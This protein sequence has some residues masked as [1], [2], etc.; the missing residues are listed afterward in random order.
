M[1]GFVK[2]SQTKLLG[3]VYD[4]NVLGLDERENTTAKTV[5]GIRNVSVNFKEARGTTSG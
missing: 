2:H 5:V 1:T 3:N 4:V